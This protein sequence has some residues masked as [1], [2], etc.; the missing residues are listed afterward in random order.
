MTLRIKRLGGTQA[1][2]FTLEVAGQLTAASPL[3]SY[4]AARLPGL[5]VISKNSWMLTDDFEAYFLYK[6]RLFVMETPFVNVWI[7]LLG[8]PAD[9]PLFAELEAEVQNYGF[10]SPL[11]A[12]FTWV[13]YLFLPANPSRE[14]LQKYGALTDEQSKRGK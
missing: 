1:E 2:P 10:F 11:C 8:Q 3:L 4:L 14:L 5:R 7:S 13:R 6:D 9:E 12:P